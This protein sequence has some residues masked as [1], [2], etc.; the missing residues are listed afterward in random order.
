MS[1]DPEDFESRNPPRARPTGDSSAKKPRPPASDLGESTFRPNPLGT[2][3]AGKSRGS[4]KSGAYGRPEKFEVPV[5]GP[6]WWERILFG[7]ISSGQLS[8]FCRQ[9]ASYLNAG[10][11]I[12]RALASLE[13]QNRG[14][15]LGPVL[16][17]VLVSIRR[18]STLEEAMAHEPR[19]FGPMFLNMI[20]VAEA[21]GGVPETLKMLA[22]HFEARQRLIRQARSAMIYPAIVVILASGVVALI[23]VVLLPMFV[24]LL[25]DISKKSA[26]PWPSRVLM[27]F[28]QFVQSGGWWIIPSVAIGTPF[29]LLR[30]Y[31]TA[32]GKAIMDRLIL[33]VP[34]FG[35]LCR[36]IDT[37]R[38]ARTLSVLLNAGVDIGQSIDLTADVLM[39]SPIQRAVRACREQIM[40]G[41]ELSGTLASSRQF[42]PDVIAV[43]GSGEETG[44]LPESLAH[45]ADDYEEQVSITVANLGQLVQPLL[46]GFV[47]LI[48]LFIIL[49]VFLPYIQM[50]TSLSGG[51]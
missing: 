8:Q 24:S 22:Q 33:M 2:G 5:G 47:G 1:R 38:F 16:S 28:S 15:A 14:A 25:A 34:V 49:A 9:F 31:K 32:P 44:K 13:K 10:V 50:I 21:R 3:S 36:K 43:I 37:T 4:K 48:V 11:D 6:S 26:L 17:R 12:T 45:L 40:S 41:K 51:G 30:I 27:G 19:A 23:T 20:K 39:M 7:R 18:G 29:V 35:S 46:I 42:A